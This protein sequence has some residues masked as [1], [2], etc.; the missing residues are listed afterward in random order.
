MLLFGTD[1]N[2][3]NRV[4]AARPDLLSR[5][6]YYEYA[7]MFAEQLS[8]KA[9]DSMFDLDVI[10][11]TIT[12]WTAMYDRGERER[13]ML[14]EKFLPVFGEL[15]KKIAGFSNQ[16]FTEWLAAIKAD[17]ALLKELREEIQNRTL[18]YWFDTLALNS[19]VIS[20]EDFTEMLLDFAMVG[21]T[22]KTKW[23][24]Q[25]F[26]NM[27]AMIFEVYLVEVLIGPGGS[28]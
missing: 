4:A 10:V 20:E 28:S 18:L 17:E 9:I 8:M 13:V 12:L 26:L 21:W 24:S 14:G 16:A 22:F 7:V 11:R 5:S 6:E 19:Q 2:V 15:A 3:V 1:R 25:M 27:Q 23:H